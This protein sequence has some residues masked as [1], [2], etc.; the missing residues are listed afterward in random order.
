MGRQRSP[1]HAEGEHVIPYLRAA[2]V[3]DGALV[4]DDVLTMNFTP[5][6]QTKYQLREGDV[7]VTEGCGSLSQ[8]G[9]SARWS[10]EIA[11]PVAFQNTLLRLRAIDGV[12]DP[13]FVYQW[14]RWAFASGIFA[15]TASG[16]NIFH[17][18][19][20]R[21]D[22][23]PFPDLAVEEQRE[24]ADVLSAVDAAVEALH[25]ESVA[26]V[27]TRDAYL[28]DVFRSSPLVELRSFASF[29]NGTTFPRRYQGD[30][31]GMFPFYKV[32]DS[33]TRGN[34]RVL[35]QAA[36]R[37]SEEARLQL[38]ARIWPPGAVVFPRV[39]GALASE[40]RRQLGHEALVDDNHLVAVA[41][42]GVDPDFLFACLQ[43][44]KLAPL[45]QAGVVPSINQE[46]VGALLVPDA[47]P[48]EQQVIGST[49]AAFDDTVIAAL[50]AYEALDQLRKSLLTGLFTG[51][52]RASEAFDVGR[53]AV[54][55]PEVVLA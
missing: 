19:A 40:K 15:E 51:T 1:R 47:D 44:L 6:E 38:R 25:V 33:N 10:G 39:G 4:L 27:R 9:A 37:L 30:Q 31:E 7:L 54:N 17:I 2:N 5:A 49:C 43:H 21:A 14:A 29:A 34:E 53:S 45:A 46:I 50:R 36:N 12:S 55:E 8:I 52:L 32:S 23:L 18:G 11:G 28:E 24:I 48:A 41:L 20:K 22:G 42:P 3:K 35:T 16:S 13:A 26:T